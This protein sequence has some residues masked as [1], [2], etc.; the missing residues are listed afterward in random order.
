MR[1][2]KGIKAVEEMPCVPKE[3]NSHT[4]VGA[5]VLCWFQAG[6]W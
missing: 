1:K 2:R 4:Q 5:N 6:C 3:F